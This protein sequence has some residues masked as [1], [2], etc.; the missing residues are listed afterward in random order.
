ME[1][2]TL[3]SRRL[4][5]RPSARKKAS[6]SLPARRFGAS[7]WDTSSNSLDPETSPIELDTLV[8]HARE[9]ERSREPGFAALSRWDTLQVF[10]AT[11]PISILILGI[12]ALGALLGLTA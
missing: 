4:E 6:L 9:C 5:T 2:G 3:R 8:D 11:R 1:A 7:A 12:L 10:V